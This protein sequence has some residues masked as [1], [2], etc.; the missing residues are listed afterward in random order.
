MHYILPVNALNKLNSLR[1]EYQIQKKINLTEKPSLFGLPKFFGG[2]D[3]ESRN[4]QTLFLKQI[5]TLL[6]LHLLKE[7]DIKT[8]GQHEGY[9]T[10]ARFYIAA[11]LYI[12]PQLTSNSVLLKIINEDLGITATNYLDQ[13]DKEICILAAT[14]LTSASATLRDANIT[15]KKTNLPPISEKEW[16]D[17]TDFLKNFTINKETKNP[18]SNYPITSITQPLCKAGF[19]YVGGAIGLLVGNTVSRSMAPREKLTAMIGTVCLVLGTAGT[20]GIAIIGPVIAEN[21]MTSFCSISLAHIIGKS[22][23]I[24]GQGVGYGIG[25]PL[26]ISYRLLWQACSTI[27]EY[28]NSK[29]ENQF[30]SGT[31]ISDGSYL[32]KGNIIKL[33]PL[34]EIQQESGLK[35]VEVQEDGLLSNINKPIAQPDLP[36]DLIEELTKNKQNKS[37]EI[38]PVVVSDGEYEASKAII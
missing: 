21:L 19:M 17:F 13:E 23:G 9:V 32:L 35:I 37:D 20:T 7:A 1:E 6:G 4:K 29:N 31:R 15:L 27:G 5:H 14:R 11:C 8:I 12:M 25:M 24:L 30:L 3:V 36:L 18:Y 28:Y 16:A 38:N 10:A 26:D 2:V 22:M 33:T 34:N